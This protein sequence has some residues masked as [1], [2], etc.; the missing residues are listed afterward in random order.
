M[1]TYYDEKTYY[2]SYDGPS[3][4]F[5][6]VMQLRTVRNTSNCTVHVRRYVQTTGG[7]FKGTTIKTDWGESDTLYSN[8]TYA[9][10]GWVTLGTYSY[11]T[12][13]S[14]SGKSYYTGG[15]GTTYSSTASASYLPSKPTYTVSYDANTTDTVSNLPSNQ[16][17]TYGTALTISK[18]VPTREGYNF[19]NWNTSADGSGT[20]YA[21][22]ASYTGNAA[23]KL[24]AQWELAYHAPIV[25]AVTVGRC[26]ADE[27][28]DDY[29]TYALVT[30]L[31][32]TDADYGATV[33][34]ATVTLDGGS[35]VSATLTGTTEGTC[36]AKVGGSLDS[37]TSYKVTVSVTDSA[38]GTGVAAGVIP[39][40]MFPIDFLKAGRGVAFGKPASQE[41]YADFGYDV[42]M[43]GSLW[44][45]GRQYGANLPLWSGGYYMTA[46]QSCTLSKSISNQPNGVVLI[47]S[48][49]SSSASQ[50]YNFITHF[51]PK[52]FVSLHGGCGMNFD[53]GNQMGNVR[54]NKYLYI[55]DTSITGHASNGTD[56][57]G[58]EFNVQNTCWVLRYVIGV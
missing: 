5:R 18:A 25:S 28:A 29:G 32:E 36:S 27:N 12:T 6:T 8:G 1:A 42:S 7:S 51:I 24:Y 10:S 16:T 15:S 34:S 47:W 43:D 3:C 17:K 22:G 50:N 19:L 13:I 20:S 38:G 14:V 56:N 9:D 21:S 52:A 57:A 40:V 23:L 54:M 45:G 44:V 31:W 46:S 41:R 48:Y 53:G 11:G 33:A 58:D 49:Y 39:A 30:F 35:P 37:E 26:D 4:T 2:G 55:N